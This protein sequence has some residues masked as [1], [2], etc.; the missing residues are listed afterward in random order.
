MTPLA[1]RLSDLVSD[2]L[3]TTARISEVSELSTCFVKVRLASEAFRRTQWI[4]GDK[5]QIR[6]QRGS[7]RM[8]AYTPINWDRRA[9]STDLIAFRHGD[10]PGARWFEDAAVGTDC[11]V[12]GPSRSLDLSDVAPSA[13]FVGDET[14]VALAHALHSVNPADR[15]LYETT[16]PSALMAVL[17]ALGLAENVK[18]MDKSDNHDALLQLIIESVQSPGEPSDL[19]VSGDAAT[20]SAVRRGARRWGDYRPQIK[21]RAYWAHGRTGLS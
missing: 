7:L 3:F 15:Y 8:R 6:P 20:V 2:V 14:S 16:D 19:I 17:T 13:V 9:G 12:F 1:S 11:D 10:G 4:P 21:A 5:L 18:V